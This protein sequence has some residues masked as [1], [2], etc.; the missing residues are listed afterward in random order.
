MKGADTILLWGLPTDPP[1]SA[2]RNA[3]RQSGCKITFLDQRTVRE[4]SVELV[5]GPSVDGSLRVREE[6]LDLASVKAFYLRP[7]D[8][9][10]LRDFAGAGPNSELFRHALAIHDVLF[11]WADLTPALV[12][13]RPASMAPNY[14]KPYQALWTESLGFQIPDTLITTDPDAALDFWRRHDRVIYKSMS[15][16]R[17]VVSRLTPDHMR[18][19]EHIASCPTQFQEYIP[20]TEYRVHVVGEKMF[21][22]EIVSQADDYRYGAERAAMQACEL[23][24]DVARL[25]RRLVKSMEL[26]LAGID[27]RR[28]PDDRWYCLEVNP[29]PSFTWF[30]EVTQQPIA[31]A[32]AELLASGGIL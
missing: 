31:E 30:E 14:S 13:N 21:A 25:C 5:A 22:C 27:L 32:V 19:F 9:G 3:L 4:T 23:P 15:G 10:E 26:L 6:A 24:M 8:P 17:S 12:L 7:Q 18:R 20:G 11:S 16:I 1:L 29:S 2:V 28:T